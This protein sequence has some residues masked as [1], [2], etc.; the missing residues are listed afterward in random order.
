MLAIIQARLSSV[1]L[2]GKMLMDLCG[3]PM[4]GRVLDRVSSA[5]SIQRFVVATSNEVSDDPIARFCENERVPCHRG[6]LDDVM[7]RFQGAAR[8]ESAEAFVRISG[9]SPLIDPGVIDLAVGYYQQA[10]CDLATNVFVRTF[11]KGQSVE[12]V[13]A[14]ALEKLKQR[15]ITADHREHVTKAFYEDPR[16]FRIVSF[17]SG[18][19]A[20]A[21]NLS[22]DTRE[23]FERARRLIAALPAAGWRELLTFEQAELVRA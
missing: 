18:Y 17:T 3:R 1:R 21:V 4:L 8:A 5:R 22:V 19:D 12:V 14:A 20:G 2:P 16:W 7:E 10:D 6:P 11:P 9:D 15:A 23:D 13:R